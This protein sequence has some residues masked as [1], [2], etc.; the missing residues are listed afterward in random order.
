MPTE[1]S[2]EVQ[3]AKDHLVEDCVL[4]ALRNA[5]NNFVK[6][7]S[8]GCDRVD[9]CRSINECQRIIATRRIQRVD[10]VRWNSPD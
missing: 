9:F 8:E 1:Q 4:D 2:N 5:W 10:P 3:D 6:L 7:G